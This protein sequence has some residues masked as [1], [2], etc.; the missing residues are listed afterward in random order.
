MEAYDTT[1][2]KDTIICQH[3]ETKIFE[4]TRQTKDGNI[5]A[6]HLVNIFGDT[7]TLIDREHCTCPSC[8]E[9]VDML[10]QAINVSAAKELGLEIEIN[11]PIAIPKRIVSNN[12]HHIYDDDEN[13]PTYG[14]VICNATPWAGNPSPNIR[15]RAQEFLDTLI[16][17][18]NNG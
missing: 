14:V 10:N 1:A 7:I 4:F 15:Q 11:T 9:E 3:C 6:A 8:G 17:R 2:T 16:E 18:Y 5:V 13:S 12:S